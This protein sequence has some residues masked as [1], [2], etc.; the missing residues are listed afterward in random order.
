[1]QAKETNTL[2]TEKDLTNSMH[3]LS[4]RSKFTWAQQEGCQKVQASPLGNWKEPTISKALLGTVKR[5]WQMLNGVYIE[6]HLFFYFYFL[7]VK[8]D[9]Y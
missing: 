1:M 2:D 4:I 8:K 6:R 5:K 3:S 7:I 9:T